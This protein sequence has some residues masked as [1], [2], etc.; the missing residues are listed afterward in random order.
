MSPGGEFEGD[1]IDYSFIGESEGF[2]TT[3][4]V[5]KDSTGTVFGKSGVTVANGFDLGQRNLNDL[6][7]L[8][9]ELIKKFTPYLG[10]QTEEAKQYLQENPFTLSDEEAETVRNFA[11]KQETNKV[12]TAYQTKTGK[13]FYDLPAAAQTVIADVA[14]QHGA[15]ASVNYKN[16]G[17]LIKELS[18]NPKNPEIY[19]RMQDELLNFTSQTDDSG[20][21]LYFNRRE[22]EAKLL[23]NYA[24]GLF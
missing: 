19:R 22:R 14:Y 1:K 12:V 21:M 24:K 2:E 8:P 18:D 16:W 4:Y 23:D 20:K 15:E 9:P 17:G 7:G 10:K 5:P 3:A 11:H 6:Q 13:N